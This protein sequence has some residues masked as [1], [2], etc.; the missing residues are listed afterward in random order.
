MN[1]SVLCLFKLLNPSQSLP[2]LK[3]EQRRIHLNAYFAK[4]V[5]YGKTSFNR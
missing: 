2:L 3:G 1:P 5:I 4:G